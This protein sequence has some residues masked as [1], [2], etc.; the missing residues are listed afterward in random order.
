[1]GVDDVTLPQQNLVVATRT[2]VIREEE[3][4][5]TSTR[6]QVEGMEGETELED[7]SAMDGSGKEDDCSVADGKKRRRRWL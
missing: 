2:T 3:R 5:G 7:S 4:I 1:M 6:V